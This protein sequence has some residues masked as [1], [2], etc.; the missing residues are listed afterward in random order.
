VIRSPLLGKTPFLCSWAVLLVVTVVG[1][2]GTFAMFAKFPPPALG[3]GERALS[4][5]RRGEFPAG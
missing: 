4:T 2:L 5:F 3:N 1:T